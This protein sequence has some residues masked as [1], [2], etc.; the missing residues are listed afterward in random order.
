MSTIMDET[1][2]IAIT[3]LGSRIRVGGTAEL[4]GYDRT[5]RPG[6]R[7]ALEHSVTDLFPGAL[8]SPGRSI[9]LFRETE[10]GSLAHPA[11]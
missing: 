11:P 3:R 5:L 10:K 8:A 9:S 6:R 4:S 2:K 1:Y 7:L